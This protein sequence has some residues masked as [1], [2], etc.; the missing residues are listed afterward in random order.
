MLDIIPALLLISFVL[1]GWIVS[2]IC[3]VYVIHKHFD[4]PITLTAIRLIAIV[5]NT[6]SICL[7]H[8]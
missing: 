4:Y 3:D 6:V 5:V 7:N 1:L 2:E 8:I